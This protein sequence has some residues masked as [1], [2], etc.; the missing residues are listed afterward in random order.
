MIEITII[1]SIS[2]NPPLERYAPRFRRE[3]APFMDSFHLFIQHLVRK[4]GQELCPSYQSLYFVPSSAVP[5]DFEYTSKTFFPPQVVES[6]SSP[7]PRSPQSALPVIGSMGTLRR[8]RSLLSVPVPSCTPRTNV[9][10][11]GG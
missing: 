7:V 2:V 6:A 5:V 4:L 1:S 11:S 9:S 8:N 3:A 10:R